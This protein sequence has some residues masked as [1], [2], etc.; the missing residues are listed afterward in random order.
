MINIVPVNDLKEHTEES[1]CDCN[2][3]LVIENGEMIL[4]HN[5]YDNRD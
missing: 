5:A 2:P 1:T 3:E 4:V